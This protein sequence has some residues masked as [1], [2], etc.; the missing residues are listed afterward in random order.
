MSP[1]FVDLLRSLR[2][3]DVRCVVVGAYAVDRLVAVGVESLSH[4]KG[5]RGGGHPRGVAG[6]WNDR[7]SSLPSVL[8]ARML[9]PVQGIL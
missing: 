6:L 1:D 5:P 4:A 2:A 9:Y 8:A 7:P 3:A